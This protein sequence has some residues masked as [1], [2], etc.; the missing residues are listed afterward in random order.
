MHRHQNDSLGSIA[1]RC[2]L[3]T[4]CNPTMTNAFVMPL[5]KLLISGPYYE[6]PLK[7]EGAAAKMILLP[8]NM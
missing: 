2:S 1:C 8:D 4:A 3:A 7:Y 5:L 6:Y